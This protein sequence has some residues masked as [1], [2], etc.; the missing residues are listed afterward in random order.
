MTAPGNDSALV[1]G[2]PIEDQNK[3]DGTQLDAAIAALRVAVLALERIAVDASAASDWA[4][5]ALTL[6]E[7]ESEDA[8]NYRSGDKRLS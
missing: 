2:A 1:A 7:L 5:N 6:L 3:G 8:S 4:R